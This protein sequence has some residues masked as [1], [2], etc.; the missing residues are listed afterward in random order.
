M[1]LHEK[2]YN[3]WI[4]RLIWVRQLILSMMLGLRD[5]NVVAQRLTRNSSDFGQILGSI[6][7]IDA[8]ERFNYLLTQYISTL[9][10]VVSTIKA[11]Q[12]IA[13]LMQNWYSIVDEIVD[14]LFQLNS[15]WVKDVIQS[16]IQRQ[17][18]LELEYAYKL[19]R[20]Q[21]AEGVTNFDFA[22]DNAIKAAQIMLYGIKAQLVLNNPR[23]PPPI[24]S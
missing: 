10:E 19:N 6:Y 17:L 15:Y 3:L 18:Q 21:F 23:V 5:V 12:N 2:I 24:V 16:L 4:D 13:P 20:G 11:G 7:G 8:R 9:S 1:N 22:Y 14:F